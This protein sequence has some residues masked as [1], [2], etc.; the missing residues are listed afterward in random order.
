MPPFDGHIGGR[1][2]AEIVGKRHG[3]VID[4][5][6]PAIDR[7]EAVGDVGEEDRRVVLEQGHESVRQHL[8]RAVAD[9][10]LLRRHAMRAG[11][12][13]LEQV[14]VRVGVEAQACRIVA[15]FRLDRRQHAR[16]GRVGIFVGVELDQVGDLGLLARHVR[17][18]VA[19]DLAPEA[20]HGRFH[21]KRNSRTKWYH[22]PPFQ[23]LC[24]LTSC[25]KL[26]LPVIPWRRRSPCVSISMAAAR[27]SSPPASLSS[28]TCSTRSPG[29]G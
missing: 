3:A 20:T 29:T 5:V 2:D 28:T 4:A 10:D 21:G 24:G 1:V 6:Q 11:D 13:R 16:R 7:V 23:R 9:E 8:V 25:G 18:E 14:G 15:E 12:G 22:G 19:D 26:K 27:A 17:G